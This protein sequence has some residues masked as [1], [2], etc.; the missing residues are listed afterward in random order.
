[1]V[2]SRW[3]LNPRYDKDFIEL[4]PYFL[5]HLAIYAA[6]IVALFGYMRGRFGAITGRKD[7]E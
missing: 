3:N 1:M 6:G 7:G 5:A 2:E 4:I